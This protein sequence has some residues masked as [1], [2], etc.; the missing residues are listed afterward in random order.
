MLF[1]GKYSDFF[2]DI[3]QDEK[4]E[5]FKFSFDRVFYE[6]S[7]QAD[8]YEFLALHIIREWLCKY[9]N[10]ETEIGF[11]VTLG[12]YVKIFSVG[13]DCWLNE[14]FMC[15]F[16]NLVIRIALD[17]KSNSTSLKHALLSSSVPVCMVK[18]HRFNDFKMWKSWNLSL[19][20][21]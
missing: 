6:N 14:Q 9:W 7:E 18:P 1:V 12:Q 17:L 8:V 16:W 21:G 3:W 13:S 2:H 4:D 15:K 5:D 10:L 19:G 11:L 20:V